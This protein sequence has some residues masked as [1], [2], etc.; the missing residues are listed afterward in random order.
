[1]ELYK[2]LLCRDL[3]RI[4][5]S[6]LECL[7]FSAEDVESRALALLRDI[8]A[9]VRAEH[10]TDFEMAEDIVSLFEEFGLDAGFRH[11]FG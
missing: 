8:Q 4:L 11:D 2:E 3:G 6:R 7:P 5:L 9:I 10:R 1:M